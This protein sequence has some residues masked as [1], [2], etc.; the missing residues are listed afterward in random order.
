MVARLSHEVRFEM[1]LKFA[2]RSHIHW[3]RSLL[4]QPPAAAEGASVEQ[5]AYRNP[6]LPAF[7]SR[8][9]RNNNYF[10]A[11]GVCPLSSVGRVGKIRTCGG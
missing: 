8:Q 7:S 2:R 4:N 6:S 9:V 1:R 11:H 10:R 5:D 3:P